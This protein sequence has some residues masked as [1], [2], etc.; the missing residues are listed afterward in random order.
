MQAIDRT[1]H[2]SSTR[3]KNTTR[4]Q[5][6]V[7][8]DCSLGIAETVFTLT[9]EILPDRTTQPRF[10]HMVR[11]DKGK[12]QP[13]GQLPPHCGFTGTGQSNQAEY[14]ILNPGPPAAA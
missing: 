12:L 11:V 3:G 2:R 4:T 6:Q 1:Q 10:D 13:A 5:R 9:L 8:D 14:Q 7:I